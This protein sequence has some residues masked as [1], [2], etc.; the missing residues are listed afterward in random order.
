MSQDEQFSGTSG[1]GVIHKFETITEPDPDFQYTGDPNV[2]NNQVTLP[3]D[4]DTPGN[5]IL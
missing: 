1:G 5:M 2:V 4:G 3:V